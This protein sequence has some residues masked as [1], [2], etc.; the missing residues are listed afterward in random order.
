M[1]DMNTR[2]G[3]DYGLIEDQVVDIFT[4]ALKVDTFNKLEKKLE[5]AIVKLKG[6]VRE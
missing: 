3:I 4:K 1:L 5:M 6:D 2:E